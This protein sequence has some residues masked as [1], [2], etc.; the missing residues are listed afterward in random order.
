MAAEQKPSQH[1]ADQSAVYHPAVCQGMKQIGRIRKNRIQLGQT[2][3]KLGAESAENQAPDHKGK[4]LICIQLQF[5]RPVFRSQVSGN[6]AD[7]DHQPVSMNGD[8]P[9]GKQFIF[10]NTFLLIHRIVPCCI[11]ALQY[12][13]LP[14]IA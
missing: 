7:S 4:H 10:H 14:R 11:T 1:A 3:Q 2:K 9:Y 12:K 13:S 5:S 8:R 6:H